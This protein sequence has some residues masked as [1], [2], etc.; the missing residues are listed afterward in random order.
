MVKSGDIGSE[1]PNK[2]V[3]DK[4]MSSPSIILQSDQLTVSGTGLA[5][6]RT[7]VEQ[8]SA[9]WEWRIE[10][11]ETTTDE[12]SFGLVKFGVC[13]R[14]N[15][16]FYQALA[17]H[18]ESGECELIQVQKQMCCAVLW[19][20]VCMFFTPLLTLPRFLLVSIFLSAFFSATYVPYLSR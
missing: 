5:L 13:T 12:D 6:A 7:S 17:A 15:S 3:I 11:A 16:E 19:T 10:S 8:D 9:Y 4:A 1:L 18:E 20:N 14:K 2:I